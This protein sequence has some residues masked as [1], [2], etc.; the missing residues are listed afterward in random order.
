MRKR[1]K[2]GKMCYVKPMGRF[3]L[4][5]KLGAL[6]C[7]IKLA[8]SCAVKQQNIVEKKKNSKGAGF[9]VT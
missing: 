9:V 2:G 4:M 3:P 5:V 1:S 6:G 8:A 7:A